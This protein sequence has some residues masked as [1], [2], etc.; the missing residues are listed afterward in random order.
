MI[1]SL[2]ELQKKT[3][4]RA[5]NAVM[6][7]PVIDSLEDFIWEGVFCY[8]KG[9]KL[10]DP[11]R[12]IR[13]KA[14]FDVVG[15]FSDAQKT[16]IGWSAKNVGTN[17]AASELKVQ[18]V[19]QRANI[20]GKRKELGFPH[21]TLEST[22]AELGLAV[23]KHWQNKVVADME[24]QGVTDARICVLMKGKKHTQYAY[25]EEKLRLY[26]PEEITW[27][28]ATSDRK[29]LQ[30]THAET[31]RQV[32]TW[33]KSGG[34]LFETFYPDANTFLFEVSLKRMPFEEVIRRLQV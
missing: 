11:L 31:G 12:T 13:S 32:Y 22:P 1:Y 10:V 20:I 14:L 19:I 28:W 7:I 24:T 2:T 15:K 23:M 34:Q 30:G 9:L 18:L 3:L 17:L 8:I 21:L 5:V 25:F 27:A 6:S 4:V 29:G 16:R 26:S 33:Y